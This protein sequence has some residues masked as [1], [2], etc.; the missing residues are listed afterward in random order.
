MNNIFALLINMCYNEWDLNKKYKRG[1]K[2]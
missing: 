1:E 2:V